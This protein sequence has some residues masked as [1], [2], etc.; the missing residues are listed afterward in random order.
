MKV[1]QKNIEKVEGRIGAAIRRLRETLGITQFELALQLG[2]RERNI[3]RWENGDSDPGGSH[4]IQIMQLCPDRASL[5]SFGVQVPALESKAPAGKSKEGAKM[6]AQVGTNIKDPELR[7]LYKRLQSDLE[8]IDSHA[9]AGDKT[10][11]EMRSAIAQ[12]I[13]GSAGL[14]TEPGLSKAQRAKL[15]AEALREIEKIDS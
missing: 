9:E 4:L 6:E 15:L 3:Q 13:I 11:L 12:R 1:R 10:A 5:E 8:V 2:T 7:E 14:A